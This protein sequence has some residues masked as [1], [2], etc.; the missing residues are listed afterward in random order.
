M[1]SD[2]HPNLTPFPAAS[3]FTTKEQDATVSDE[4]DS[5]VPSSTQYVGFADNSDVL[6]PSELNISINNADDAGLLESLDGS[7]WWA[8]LDSWV[9]SSSFSLV[10]HFAKITAGS[11]QFPERSIG[12]PFSRVKR[13]PQHLICLSVVWP[14]IGLDVGHLLSL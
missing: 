14:R 11:V 1:G 13:C 8:Q 10:Q 12:I 4:I 7:V 3:P 2:D 5:A 9:L 6:Q